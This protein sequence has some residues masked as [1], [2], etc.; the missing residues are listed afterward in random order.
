ML[1]P[2]QRFGSNSDEF[3]FSQTPLILKSYQ[4]YRAVA[5]LIH[6]FPKPWRYSI[7]EKLQ[8]AILSVIDLTCQAL[9]ARQPLKEPYILKI[10]GAI[11]TVQLFVRLALEE[12][13]IEEKQYFRLSEQIIELHRMALGWL[14]STRVS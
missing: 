7:G 9:Y 4:A 3:V 12:K 11:Q 14:K 1:P 6:R 10:I 2:P 5:P 13:L 8:T